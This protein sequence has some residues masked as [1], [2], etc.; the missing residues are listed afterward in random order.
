MSASNCGNS[1]S[2]VRNVGS[3]S[4]MY[5]SMRSIVEFRRSIGS[6]R[7]SNRSGSWAAICADAGGTRMALLASACAVSRADSA[8]DR[9]SL[10]PVPS[11]ASHL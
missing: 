11:A 3:A 4:A 5:R 10:E 9:M 6:A 7:F 1:R 2:S 8:A